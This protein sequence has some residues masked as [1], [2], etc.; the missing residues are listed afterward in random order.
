MEVEER[1]RK[2]GKKRRETKEGEMEV[3]RVGRR[4]EKITTCT[5]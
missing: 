1:E 2:E 4:R 3:H 5:T